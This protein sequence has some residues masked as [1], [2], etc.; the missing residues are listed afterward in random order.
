V[1]KN[2][3]NNKRLCSKYT[4]DRARIGRFEDGEYFLDIVSSD[5]RSM[6]GHGM[7]GKSKEEMENFLKK[8]GFI[9]I[10]WK[11]EI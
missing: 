9:K 3:C 2:E 4:N 6:N 8:F 1:E 11:E 10:E 7:D 5:G